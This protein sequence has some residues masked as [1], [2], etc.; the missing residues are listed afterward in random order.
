METLATTIRDRR[1]VV[2]KMGALTAQGRFGA[3]IIGGM[4]VLVGAFVIATQPDMA[5]ALLHTHTGWM[6][7][8]L[9]G[10]LEG[11]AIVALGK[12]LQFDV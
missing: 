1:R 11:A 3:F 6:V 8:G 7:L 9:V 2:R 4:P 5:Q 10:L 12:I